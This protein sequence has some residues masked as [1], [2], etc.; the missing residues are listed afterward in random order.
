MLNIEL[1]E[2]SVWSF[3]IFLVTTG[4]ENEVIDLLEDAEDDEEDDDDEKLLELEV[5]DEE[6]EEETE[7][8]ESSVVGI[9]VD[10]GVGSIVG[11]IF[12]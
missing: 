12:S 10:A 6:E 5:D 11:S 3:F 8:C 1:F 4:S 9:A 7:D 2:V